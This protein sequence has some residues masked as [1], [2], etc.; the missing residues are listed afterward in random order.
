MATGVRNGNPPGEGELRLGLEGGGA[1]QATE[2][3]VSL[4][5]K[6]ELACGVHWNWVGGGAGTEDAFGRLSEEKVD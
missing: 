6:E 3:R 2:R 1:P 4:R 5:P